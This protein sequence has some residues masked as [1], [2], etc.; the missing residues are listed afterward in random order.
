MLGQRVSVFWATFEARNSKPTCINMIES[1]EHFST[2]SGIPPSELSG[3]KSNG[4]HISLEYNM[5]FQLLICPVKASFAIFFNL[6]SEFVEF[7]TQCYN[8]F[9]PFSEGSHSTTQFSSCSLQRSFRFCFR[10][11]LAALQE[12]SQVLAWQAGTFASSCMILRS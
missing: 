7:V 3:L 11:S 1:L 9:L 6:R 5:K 10:S 4:K 8:Y 12:F 2:Y